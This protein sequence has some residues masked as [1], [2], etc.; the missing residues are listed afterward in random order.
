[1]DPIPNPVL[2]VHTPFLKI[3]AIMK[4]QQEEKPAVHRRLVRIRATEVKELNA[5]AVVYRG[6]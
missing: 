1:M 4:G 3:D 5:N 2:G 6:L